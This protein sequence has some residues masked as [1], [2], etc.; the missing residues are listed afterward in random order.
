MTRKTVIP[1]NFLDNSHLT[2]LKQWNLNA[3]LLLYELIS[4]S[5]TFLALNEEYSF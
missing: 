4:F 5:N 1:P 3:F 2:I